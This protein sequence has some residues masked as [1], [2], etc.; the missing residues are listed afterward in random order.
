V[1]KESPDLSGGVGQIIHLF[2]FL[3]LEKGKFE[4]CT[5]AIGC[6]IF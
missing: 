2:I 5:L 3:I 6:V 1:P 4:K